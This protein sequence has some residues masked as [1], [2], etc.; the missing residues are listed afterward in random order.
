MTMKR[1]SPFIVFIALLSFFHAVPAEAMKISHL[2]C[3][4]LEN[5]HG[6][7]EKQPRFSWRLE[8]D[9]RGEKQTAYQILVASDP[10]PLRANQG[11][12]WDS[13]KIES[14]ET[15]HI[16]YMGKELL[17]R[18]PCFWKVRVWDTDGNPSPWSEPATWS[19]G[20]LEASDWQANWISF[21]D[22]TP[23]TASQNELQLPPARYYRKTFSAQKPIRRAMVYATALGVY[24]LHLNGRRISEQMFTPGWSDY[25]K[26]VYYNT[27]DVADFLAR[28][29]NAIGV[30]LA[31][32]WYSGYLGYGLLVGYGPNQCGRF[33]YGKTPSFMLQLE[34]EYEDGSTQINPTDPSWKVSRGPIVQ[35]DM[36]MGET[37][38][39]RLEQNG[40]NQIGFDDR[41]WDNAILAEEN[42]ST[43]AL[44]HD[45][46]GER[47]VEL[48]F[49]PPQQIQSYPSVPIQPTAELRP[50]EITEPDTGVSIFNMGQ[51]FS[52]VVRLKAKGPAGTRVQIRHGEMLHPDGRLMTENLRKAKATDV[53][54]LRG[55]DDFEIWSPRFTYHGFQYVE[56][57][58]LPEKPSFDTITGV[59]LHSDTPLTGSFECSDAMVNQ[60]FKNVVWTQRSNFF[61]IPTDCPQRD[62]RFGW[63]G[64]AQIY[65][66]TA[67]YNA[68]VAA[69]FTKWL[70]DLEEAQLP[71]GAFPDYAPYPMM[72]GKPNRGFATAW[73]DAGVICPYTMYQV[74]GDRRMIARHYDSMKRFM[75]FRCG[76]SPDFLGVAIG[77][78]WGDWLS[79]GQTTSVE[80]ID[81]VYFAQ[82]AKYMAEMAAAIGNQEDAAE[83]SQLYDNIKKAFAKKYLESDGRLTVDT[84]TAYALALSVDLI[85]ES[86]REQAANH[87]VELIHEN[88][89]CMSTGF[90]GTKP[91]LP[92]LTAAGYNDLAVR[93]LQ[94][95]KFPSWGYEIENGATSIWERWNSY[96]KENGFFSV[97]MNSFSHYSFGA[98]CEWMFRHLAGIDAETPGYKTISIHPHP[99]APDSNPDHKTIDWVKAEYDSI[100]GKIKS[101]WKQ[102]QDRFL[103]NVTIPVN[104]TAKIT[105]PGSSIDQIRVNDQPIS[106]VAEV[107]F[108]NGTND[109]LCFSV[110]SGNYQFISLNIS[111]KTKD[112]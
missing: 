94:N 44:F 33:I 96:T 37:Y 13:G 43:K 6:I 35:A 14:E 76:N 49:T 104:T 41:K 81:T 69:F 54:I 52:G 51:N 19:M 17:S 5:P 59:V 57:T 100:R 30:I 65:A 31:D 22:E 53:Y 47:E 93:L 103:L 70:Y 26:R 88:D 79:L 95:R 67:T 11:D 106:D 34:I 12:L 60:L 24:E 7:D 55:D 78:G 85:P 99:P 84:Q 9:R 80:Y 28:G 2:R 92:V 98:V 20:L 90:L 101:E 72:H 83:Y 82:S 27:F 56:L 4:Y 25:R 89:N 97:A 102:E 29:D 64:D 111:K 86:I 10:Q 1:L 109:C 87:L 66:R 62:E 42:G 40:W 21:R 107:R 45:Q 38:D 77:N 110:E 18:Q 71:N 16:V 58:G 91:L 23:I 61:E 105:I 112:S 32:G 46:A 68:D 63:T 50:I 39:A 3:E 15:T 75:S 8:S 108:L 74:Y 73:M 48:G 36:L